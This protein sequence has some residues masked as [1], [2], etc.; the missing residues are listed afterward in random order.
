[1]FLA[2]RVEMIKDDHVYKT[3]ELTGTSRSTF[4]AAVKSAIRTASR[5]LRHLRWFEVVE[6]RGE[7]KNGSEIH[8]QVTLK[9]GFTIDSS[10][11]QKD[12][13]TLQIFEKGRVRLPGGPSQTKRKKLRHQ[14]L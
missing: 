7:I 13:R 5:T 3:V 1:M 11:D 9:V 6:V 2:G 10:N 12:D 4:E 14:R 8:W